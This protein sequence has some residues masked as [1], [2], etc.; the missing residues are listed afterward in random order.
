M[1]RNY[2]CLVG[3]MSMVLTMAATATEAKQGSDVASIHVRMY[4]RTD[5]P[6]KQR[7]RALRT[8]GRV[9]ARAL[10][11]VYLGRLPRRHGSGPMRGCTW[12]A[13]AD[14]EYRSVRPR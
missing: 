8:A 14:H 6:Q 12:P 9:L 11:E 3:T 4:D 10:F 2:R 13:N 7:A 5:V 1:Q